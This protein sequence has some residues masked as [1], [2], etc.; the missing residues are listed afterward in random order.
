MNSVERYKM[1]P[2]QLKPA[3]APEVLVSGLPGVRQHGD[4]GIAFDGKGGLYVNVGAPSNAC[5]AKDRTPLSPGQEPCPILEKNAGICP[6]S[7]VKRYSTN[8]AYAGSGEPESQ[9][10]L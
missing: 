3:G 5:Q 8:T 4:K 1:T 6:L 9:I 7:A 10:P 2:G